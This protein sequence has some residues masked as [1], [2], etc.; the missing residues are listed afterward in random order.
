MKSKQIGSG[1]RGTDEGAKLAGYR[2]LWVDD[3][4]VNHSE[5]GTSGFNGLPAGFRD[6]VNGSYNSMGSSG[7]F[8]SSESSSSNAWNRRLWDYYSKVR[9]FSNYKEFGFSIRC[10]AD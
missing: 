6:F 9:R 5:F 3:V 2:D 1:H 7:Y 4:L 8:L 10:L